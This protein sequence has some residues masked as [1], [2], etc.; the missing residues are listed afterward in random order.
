LYGATC[1]DMVFGLVLGTA[2]ATFIAISVPPE[3]ARLEGNRRATVLGVLLGL[4]LA[5]GFLMTFS[6]AVLALSFAV[7][8]GY[9][10]LRREP[11]APL[12]AAA[13][14]I[15]AA[16]SVGCL[17]ALRPLTG[18]DWVACGATAV[19]LDGAESNAFISAGYYTV[20]R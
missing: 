17:L 1:M 15:A 7:V 12:L 10:L 4:E 20:T 13:T 14:A 19:R 3:S 9:R 11:G 6:T 18:F 8:V 5:S 16:V 2:I